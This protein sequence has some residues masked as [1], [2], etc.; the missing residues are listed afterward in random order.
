[1]SSNGK[2]L[3]GK[4]SK[5]AQ[6]S[7]LLLLFFTPTASAQNVVAE[8]SISTQT[9]TVYVDG[10]V[11]Y[12]WSVS[13]A[14]SGYKT[15]HGNYTPY[16]L[17]KNHHSSIYKNSPMPFSVFFRGNY[18]IHGTTEFK[19]LGKPVSHGCVRL[20]T[21]NAKLFFQL[22]EQFGKESTRIIIGP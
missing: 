3:V 16:L 15:P 14:R 19:N 17:S 6:V 7:L 11:L 9:M 5:L 12:K 8:V 22:V 4:V 2:N 18:A 1:M 21:E 10:L 13:T 20:L